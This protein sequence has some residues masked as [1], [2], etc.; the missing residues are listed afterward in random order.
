VLATWGIGKAGTALGQFNDPLSVAVDSPNG[1]VYIADAGN[2]RVQK[3]TTDGYPLG[4]VPLGERVFTVVTDPAGTVWAS[5]GGTLFHISADLRVIDRGRLQ[6]S[7]LGSV[8]AFDAKGNIYV[9]NAP[10]IHR[11]SSSG[12]VQSWGSSGKA[13]GQF[14]T[15]IAAISVDGHGRI[16]VLDAGNNRIQQYTP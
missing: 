15:W 16:Y 4:A 14:S 10:E 7:G 2:D 3:L 8:M 9:A 5:T 11:L 6:G 12:Q 1:A 13:P